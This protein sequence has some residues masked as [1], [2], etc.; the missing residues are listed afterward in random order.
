[1]FETLPMISFGNTELA[2]LLMG[3][4]SQSPENGFQWSRT[5]DSVHRLLSNET[6]ERVI[7]AEPRV[8]FCMLTLLL[9]TLIRITTKLHSLSTFQER[10]ILFDSL[11]SLPNYCMAHTT[12][13]NHNLP[14]SEKKF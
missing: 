8:W 12:T 9:F 10:L 3:F 13:V 4:Q 2:I 7:L 14:I 1:M 11:M 6:L 5:S